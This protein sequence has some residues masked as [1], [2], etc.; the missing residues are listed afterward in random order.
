M[1]N[2]SNQEVRKSRSSINKDDNDAP[3]AYI[4]SVTVE[5]SPRSKSS[6][7]TDVMD[8]GSSRQANGSR[9][10]KPPP[11]SSSLHRKPG[12]DDERSRRKS[13]PP[14]FDLK[15]GSNDAL[16][17]SSNSHTEQ[18]EE[19][20]Q[21][22]R[23]VHRIQH[24]HHQQQR[25]ELS[26]SSDS[27]AETIH[28]KKRAVSKSIA[29]MVDLFSSSD[30]ERHKKTRVRSK[31]E[32]PPM[33]EIYE[34]ITEKIQEDS[35]SPMCSPKSQPSG[36]I[37]TP[38]SVKQR[39]DA[40][41]QK[42]ALA[43][44]AAASNTDNGSAVVS[45]DTPATEDSS[46]ASKPPLPLRRQRSQSSEKCVSSSEDNV[47]VVAAD[48]SVRS[49]MHESSASDRNPKEKS[50]PTSS[51]TSH[52][53]WS[54]SSM[55]ELIHTSDSSV[56]SEQVSA[57]SKVVVGRGERCRSFHELFASFEPDQKRIEK[58]RRLRKSA[59]EEGASEES[60]IRTFHSEPDL[61]EGRR[62]INGSFHLTISVN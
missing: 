44:Q 58:L 9:R 19:S 29:K 61:R 54:I 38:R 7:R 49:D 39:H 56:S 20:R 46:A 27:S 21:M 48:E 31:P 60:T 14:D 40:K 35:C 11:R 53:R 8:G 18:T 51:S 13:T 47:A 5:R 59:S 43:Q 12:R 36:K 15:Q 26:C 41:R 37:M 25:Q 33:S 45:D 34:D 52:N 24:H 3:R 6:V 16:S 17:Q 55:R 42:A 28:Q 2:E 10:P 32:Q 1:A 22:P 62:Q 23:T 30:E 50:S 57:S 4:T